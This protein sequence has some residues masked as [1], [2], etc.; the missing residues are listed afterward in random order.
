MSGTEAES[1]IRQREQRES[2]ALIK[3]EPP[4]L[5]LA[6]WEHIASAADNVRLPTKRVATE[7]QQ[8]D[9]VPSG[10]GHEV[11]RFSTRSL[12]RSAAD[13]IPQS[14]VYLHF[15]LCPT[16]RVHRRGD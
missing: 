4:T 2:C 13:G 10:L 11:C 16:D 9:H 14:I 1:D 3:A 8:A 12:Q 15:G 5:T 6:G 7:P